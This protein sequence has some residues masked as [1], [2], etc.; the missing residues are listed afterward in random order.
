MRFQFCGCQALQG[1]HLLVSGQLVHLAFVGQ[2]HHLF[3]F[4]VQAIR[5]TID[6]DR[7]VMPGQQASDLDHAQD[8]LG[9]DV[10]QQP[11]AHQFG[12]CG[13]EKIPFQPFLA[14]E[15]IK[16]IPWGTP[17]GAYGGFR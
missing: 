11:T 14:I 4:L 3:E 9:D 7:F 12:S 8:F 2:H 17:E 10:G 15:T 6:R 16:L 13:F 1:K 5:K